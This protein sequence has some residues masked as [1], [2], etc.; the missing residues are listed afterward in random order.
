MSKH[1]TILGK[2]YWSHIL[3]VKMSPKLNTYK[4]TYKIFKK[5]FL[6]STFKAQPRK[7]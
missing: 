3:K 1:K 6:T 5:K 4:R 7:K 2:L